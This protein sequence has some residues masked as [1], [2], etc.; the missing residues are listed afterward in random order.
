MIQR[1]QS[2]FLAIIG[3]V[4]LFFLFFP[5]WTK[6]NIQSNESAEFTAMHL[7]YFKDKEMTKK[8]TFFLTGLVFISS[9]LAFGSLFSYKDRLKQMKIN[10][11]NHLL[12]IIVTGFCLYYILWEAETLFQPNIK[13]NYKL[14]L[15]L[16]GVALLCNSIANKLIRKDEKRVRSANR[17][18]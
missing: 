16:P 1:P 17:I 11:A 5:I 8:Y 9:V 14:T 6:K 12:I 15:V 10:L 18:R 2:I 4:M 13:G 7:T 3:I